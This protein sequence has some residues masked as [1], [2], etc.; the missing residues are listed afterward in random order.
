METDFTDSDQY[1]TDGD[2]YLL[3]VTDIYPMV[4]E[5]S[6]VPKPQK[7]AKIDENELQHLRNLLD[8]E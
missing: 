1:I 4:T 2:Q 7:V 5:E 3:M 6:S 8:R